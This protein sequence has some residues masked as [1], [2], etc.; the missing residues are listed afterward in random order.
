[1]DHLTEIIA[2]GTPTDVG[3]EGGND[4]EKGFLIVDK[5]EDKEGEE[6]E[7]SGVEEVGVLDYEKKEGGLLE[8]EK[9]EEE[10]EED[11]IGEV[12][13]AEAVFVSTWFHG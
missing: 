1:M 9:E 6:K 12:G 11:M 4:G 10:E 13:K 3:A 2:A 8:A 5:D 7:G